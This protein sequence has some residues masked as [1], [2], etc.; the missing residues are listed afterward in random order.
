M[1]EPIAR[2]PP[3]N[4]NVIGFINLMPINSGNHDLTSSE[5]GMRRAAAE[6]KYSAGH[7]DW[8]NPLSNVVQSCNLP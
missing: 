7:P 6:N 3:A 5:N 4:K 8:M 2:T 1:T